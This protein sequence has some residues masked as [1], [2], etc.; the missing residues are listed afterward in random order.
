MAGNWS[1]KRAGDGLE[2]LSGIARDSAFRFG[3]M[4]LGVAEQ[5][6]HDQRGRGAG[7]GVVTLDHAGVDAAKG[8][9]LESVKDREQAT[10]Q[11][12]GV[13]GFRIQAFSH[14]FVFRL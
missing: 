4:E 12:G 3:Q 13:A 6:A 11:V 2:V 5:A 7:A 1:P 9:V 8:E 10:A 14:R